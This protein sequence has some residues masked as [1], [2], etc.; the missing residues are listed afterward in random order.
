MVLYPLNDL[1]AACISFLNMSGSIASV[2]HSSLGGCLTLEE[3][4][5]VRISCRLLLDSFPFFVFCNALTM[6]S[7]VVMSVNHSVGLMGTPTR[8]HMM[9]RFRDVESWVQYEMNVWWA[10]FDR[11]W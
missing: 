1:V 7:A 10:S 6:V 9:F 8:E 3:G 11:W 5:R 4:S 2:P